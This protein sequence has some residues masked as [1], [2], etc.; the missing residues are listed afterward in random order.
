M[1]YICDNY[2]H[3]VCLPYS[4]ENLHKMAEALGIKRCWYE[5]G[6]YDIPKRRLAEIKN[7]CKIVSS[8]EIVRIIG[9]N[10]N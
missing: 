2:R 8:K 6:H 10:P 1:E 9:S 7:Q 4:I 3:L 5:K